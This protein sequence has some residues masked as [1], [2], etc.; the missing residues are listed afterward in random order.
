MNFPGGKSETS[1]VLASFSQG[2]TGRSFVAAYLDYSRGPETEMWI[3]S[4]MEGGAQQ[5]PDEELINEQQLFALIRRAGELEREYHQPRTTPG[6]LLLG[7]CSERVLAVLHGKD[8]VETAKEPW[9]KFIFDTDSSI[10]DVPLP[11]SDFSWGTVKPHDLGLVISRTQI[12]RK[13]SVT[14]RHFKSKYG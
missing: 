11:S 8:L 9:L 14:A 1:H 4:T 12:P 3:F 6:I 2:S 13:E 10:P 5:T 7:S